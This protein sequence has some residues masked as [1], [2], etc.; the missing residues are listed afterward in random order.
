MSGRF[1]HQT[2]GHSFAV[3]LRAALLAQDHAP[4]TPPVPEVSAVRVQ[5]TVLPSTCPLPFIVHRTAPAV[6]VAA[7]VPEKPVNEMAQ[8]FVDATTPKS[9]IRVG[10]VP[11]EILSSMLVFAGLISAKL[12]VTCDLAM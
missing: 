9:V 4:A 8:R 12:A 7:V 5:V 10:I 1:L 11:L 6:M 2:P 3:I